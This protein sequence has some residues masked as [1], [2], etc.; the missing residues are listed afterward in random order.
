[1]VL[2]AF[3][4]NLLNKDM[5]AHVNFFLFGKCLTLRR[6]VNYSSSANDISYVFLIVEF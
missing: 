5:A 4:Q 2:Q 3:G 1:M 6:C